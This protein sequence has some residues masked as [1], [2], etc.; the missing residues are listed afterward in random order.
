M[1]DSRLGC[2][3]RVWLAGSGIVTCFLKQNATELQRKQ[4]V[5]ESR[6]T[7]SG[8]GKGS[9]RLAGLELGYGIRVKVTGSMLT[10]F[11]VNFQGCPVG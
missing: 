7:V 9:Q 6:V 3:M 1:R 11:F 8:S 4:A 10:L 5:C 2:G